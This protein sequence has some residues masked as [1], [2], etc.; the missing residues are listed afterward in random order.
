[1][2][3]LLKYLLV[4]KKSFIMGVVI[5]H[6][7]RNCKNCTKDVLCDGCD[8]LVNQNEIF[9]ANLNELKRQPPNEIGH[10]LPKYITT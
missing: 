10:V 8:K 1:M 9:S 6:K 5:S 7:V 3:Y 2:N 4:E